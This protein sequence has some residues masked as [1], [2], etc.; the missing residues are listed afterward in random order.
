[1]E[2]HQ[3]RA[4]QLKI[5]LGSRGQYGATPTVRKQMKTSTKDDRINERKNNPDKVSQAESNAQHPGR[6]G[7]QPRTG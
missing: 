2:D 3:E 6:S 1:M 5:I 7:T 4:S